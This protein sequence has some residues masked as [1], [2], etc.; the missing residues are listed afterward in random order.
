MSK[1][2]SHLAAITI[3]R[4]DELQQAKPNEAAIISCDLF[5]VEA[6]RNAAQTVS[7]IERSQPRE[8]E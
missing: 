7:F 6:A 1:A 2:L 4:Y 3:A 8:K 5:I